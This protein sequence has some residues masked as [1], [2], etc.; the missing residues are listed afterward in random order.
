VDYA[1]DLGAD[2]VAL[3]DEVLGR[4][5]GYEDARERLGALRAEL[6]PA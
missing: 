4:L 3:A 6:V 5:G 1:P 2:Y